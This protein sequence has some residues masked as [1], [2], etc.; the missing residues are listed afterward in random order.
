MVHSVAG[1]LRDGKLMLV[2]NV[3]DLTPPEVVQR[4]KALADIERGFRVL[5]SEIEIAPVYHHTGVDRL[6]RQGKGVRGM[7]SMIVNRNV[8][9]RHAIGFLFGVVVVERVDTKG[10]GR[11]GKA[12]S[13]KR[14]QGQVNPV[15]D[16]ILT[17]NRF[18]VL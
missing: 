11:I 16:A 7:G 4:Y 15:P 10:A 5:K 17:G 6:K 2:T 9:N 12:D 13:W 14:F 8:F 1:L 18:D 3:A